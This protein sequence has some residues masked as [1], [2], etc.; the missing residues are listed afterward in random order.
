MPLSARAEDVAL[1][2]AKKRKVLRPAE[3]IEEHMKLA[4]F[5]CERMGGY[6]FS[7]IARKKK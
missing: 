5:N 7:E 1:S 6:F 2:P 4:C 3:F